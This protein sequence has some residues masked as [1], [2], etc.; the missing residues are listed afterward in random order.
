MIHGTPS[1]GSSS[2]SMGPTTSIDSVTFTQTKSVELDKKSVE[3]SNKVGAYSWPNGEGKL[4]GLNDEETV[5]QLTDNVFPGL[6]SD[7][8]SNDYK[9]MI[10]QKYDAAASCIKCDKTLNKCSYYTLMWDDLTYVKGPIH[11]S[12]GKE[13]QLPIT[14]ADVSHGYA[15]NY[16]DLTNKFRGGMTLGSC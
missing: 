12:E 8:D 4:L 16:N 7:P 15:W 1:S 11:D 10:D 13:G 5:K 6:K 3:N 14:S 9:Q 2:D